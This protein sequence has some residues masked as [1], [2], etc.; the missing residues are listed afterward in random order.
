[1]IDGF[2]W[3]GPGG[4]LGDPGVVPGV[5]L[6]DPWVVKVQFSEP[7]GLPDIYPKVKSDRKE[8]NPLMSKNSTL[9]LHHKRSGD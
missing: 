2:C 7:I 3:S 1:M 9:G 5:P 8:K 4:F 6:G